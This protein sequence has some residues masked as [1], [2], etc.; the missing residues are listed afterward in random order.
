[1][2]VQAYIE[3]K[4]KG[5][6]LRCEALDNIV[7][8]IS[9]EK[10]FS[11][12]WKSKIDEFILNSDLRSIATSNLVALNESKE[13]IC[14]DLIFMIINI[15]DCSLPKHFDFSD[16]NP[17]EIDENDTVNNEYDLKS[18]SKTTTHNKGRTRTLHLTLTNGL[19]SSKSDMIIS[20]IEYERV[21]ALSCDLMPG[22]KILLYGESD[23]RSNSVT[24][25]SE[26][27]T[28]K[29]QNGILLLKPCNVKV[30]GGIVNSI[31]ES[32]RTNMLLAS[33]R[34]K[35]SIVTSRNINSKPPK[36]T[37]YT[38]NMKKLQELLN[39]AKVAQEIYKKSKYTQHDNMAKEARFNI[40][41]FHK[42]VINNN[43]IDEDEQSKKIHS[44]NKTT[45]SNN[46]EKSDNTIIRNNNTNKSITVDKFRLSAKKNKDK[47][48]D[49]LKS[50][51][52]NKNIYDDDPGAPVRFNRGK[53]KIDLEAKKFIKTTKTSVSLA[54]H[55]FAKLSIDVKQISEI[56][57]LQNPIN[58][59]N[60]EFEG[61]TDKKTGKG[62]IQ[63][64]K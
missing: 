63:K 40:E 3:D 27:K 54:D 23:A 9:D 52:D 51:K 7:E 47:K 16:L 18:G 2:S 53:E 33:Y 22:T 50:K 15:K 26:N 1:M 25:Y 34:T 43:V 12:K 30:I 11:L 4:Y 36:F 57:K 44:P 58:T 55:L 8:L 5:I 10:D 24:R 41:D 32:W 39:E 19:T 38:D 45:N 31:I 56:T 46:V 42:K 29:M 37:P 6:V 48:S 62:T 35:N 21:D 49:L 61:S 13:I 14:K 20:A 60:I 59:K 64:T 17:Y 28:L